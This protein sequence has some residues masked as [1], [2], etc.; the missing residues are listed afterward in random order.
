MSYP[1]IVLFFVFILVPHFIYAQH[2]CDCKI[3]LE[4]LIE[5]IETEYPGFGEKVKHDKDLYTSKKNMQLSKSIA[6]PKDSCIAVLQDY[7]SFFKDEHIFLQSR[8]KSDVKQEDTPVKNEIA[9][10]EVDSKMINGNI[11]YIRLSSFQYANVAL[12]AELVKQ[13]KKNIEQCKAMII[14]IR[15]NGGGTD[16]VY[17][18]LLPYV[19]TNPL[20]IMS[21]E[22]FATATLVNGLRDYAIQ[23]IK[24]DTANEIRRIDE[25]LKEY[26]ENLG[27]FVLYGDNKVIIDSIKI[28]KKGPSQV[29]ILSDSNVAS[30]GENFLFSCRQ[31]KKVKIMGVPSMGAL[32][33]GSIREFKFGCD[34]YELYL[35]TYRSTRLPGYPIDNI[36]IQ[37]DVYLDES[38]KDWIDFA[39][40]YINQ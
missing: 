33:Y 25:D 37:P 38:I 14:D 31:S 18:P 36:G 15:G 4:R 26:R 9:E 40:Q 27:K 20:R 19:L 32:D 13:N 22:F 30:A 6:A 16:D 12:V 39:V 34:N 29:I 3:S 17:Q 2:N 28:N 35:S 23:N 5:K 24:K 21:V 1:K 11:F 7:I 8:T 10:K